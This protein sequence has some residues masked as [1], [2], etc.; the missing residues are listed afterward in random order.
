MEKIVVVVTL[1]K[2]PANRNTGS[3][4]VREWFV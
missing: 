3:A 2:S 1:A 4:W